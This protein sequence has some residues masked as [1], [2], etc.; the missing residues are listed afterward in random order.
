MSLQVGTDGFR[1]PVADVVERENTILSKDSVQRP[2]YGRIGQGPWID[3]EGNT[4]PD[5]GPSR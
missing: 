3:V 5:Q 2:I 1:D 4:L